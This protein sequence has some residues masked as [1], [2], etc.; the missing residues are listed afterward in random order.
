MIGHS[1]LNSRD[2]QHSTMS[3][4]LLSAVVLLAVLLMMAGEALLSTYNERVLR[5]RGAIEAEGDVYRLMRWTYPGCFI[6]MAIEG[7]VRGPW[8]PSVLGAGLV[9]FGFAKALKLWAMTSLGFRWT[10]R[11]LI[12]PDAPLVKSGP[13]RFLRHPNYLA[14][15][16]EIAGVALTLWAPLAGLAG[17]LGFGAL[18]AARIR[19]EDRALGRQ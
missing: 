9:V 17:L 2:T 11:V 19:V 12:L 6:A 3:S 5:S 1:V 8:S 4:I 7:A 18:M 15:L 14:V 10:Y 16:G 13:Y